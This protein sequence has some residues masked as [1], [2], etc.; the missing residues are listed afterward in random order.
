MGING[1]GLLDET[2]SCGTA[3]CVSGCMCIRFLVGYLNEGSGAT[4]MRSNLYPDLKRDHYQAGHFAVKNSLSF[5]NSLWHEHTPTI[6]RIY[7]CT[8]V[9]DT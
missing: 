9:P 5:A 8:V 2:K 4:R 1:S 3:H 6:V 7:Y